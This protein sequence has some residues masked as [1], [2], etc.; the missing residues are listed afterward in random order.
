MATDGGWATSCSRPETPIALWAAVP[1][2][3]H[4]NTDEDR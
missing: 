4:D 2:A 3:L 1:Y